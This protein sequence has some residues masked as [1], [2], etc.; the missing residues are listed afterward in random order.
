VR[1]LYRQIHL[2]PS[3]PVEAKDGCQ[4]DRNYENNE[5]NVVCAHKKAFLGGIPFQS[6]FR[7]SSEAN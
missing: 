1:H 3:Y 4:R 5:T 7:L 6:R 2:C